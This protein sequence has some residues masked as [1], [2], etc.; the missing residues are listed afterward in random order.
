MLL[1]NRIHIPNII[2]EV[3]NIEYMLTNYL[4]NELFFFNNFIGD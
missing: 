4:S 2:L 3:F 1:S